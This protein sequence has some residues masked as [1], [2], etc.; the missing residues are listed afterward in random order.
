MNEVSYL[1][2]SADFTIRESFVSELEKATVRVWICTPFLSAGGLNII[3]NHLKKG[4][5]YRL[6]SRLNEED[7][8]G[9]LIDPRAIAVYIEAGG[10]ARFH[11]KTLHAKLWIID[12]NIFVGSVNLTRNGLTT[13][14]EIMARII[15]G[16]ETENF[17]PDKWFSTTWARLSHTELSPEKLR[18]IADSVD[19]NPDIEGFNSHKKKINFRD[20]GQ[21]TGS[22]LSYSKNHGMIRNSWLKINGRY[23]NRIDS[24]YDFRQTYLYEGG[25]ASSRHPRGFQEGDRVILARLAT[26]DDGQHDYCIYGRGTVDTEHRLGVDELPKW[27]HSNNV[28]SSEAFENISR[29]RYLVWLRNVQIINDKAKN[30]IWLSTM[31]EGHHEPVISTKSLMQKSYIRLTSEKMAVI[32]QKLEKLFRLKKPIFLASPGQVWWNADIKSK[33]DYI[34]KARLE[35]E[36]EISGQ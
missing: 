7:I 32:D 18:N 1:P 25:Q 35:A 27:L 11:P 34:T 6:I 19:V 15:N 5:D 16:C 21:M 31:N 17:S 9:R 8:A 30:A 29:Y 33:H 12:N 23:N 13:K 4:I 2:E 3:T 24:N 26:N 36:A 22:N 14:I 10:K 28:K 20:F